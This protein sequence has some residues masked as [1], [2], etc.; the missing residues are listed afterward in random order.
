MSKEEKKAAEK[1]PGKVRRVQVK[2]E[3]AIVPRRHV[4]TNHVLATFDD[5][6]DDFSRRFRESMWTPWDWAIE[7]YRV[8]F[9]MREAYADLVDEGNK[10]LVRAEIPGVPRD[11]IDVSVTK[12]GIEI[13]GETGAE[14]EEKEKNFIVRERSYSSIYRSLAFPEEVI[15][16]KAESKVKDGVLEVSVPKKTPVPPA[17]K[18]KVEVKEAK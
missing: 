10:F 4:P 1:V 13:S 8:E 16:E 2:R 12:D 3:R 9:P 14:K 6:L 15:P 17:K 11:K 7:P 5:M 18:H